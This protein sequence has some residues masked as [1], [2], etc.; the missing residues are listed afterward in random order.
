MSN[1]SDIPSG[2]VA[3]DQRQQPPHTAEERQLIKRVFGSPQ[4]IPGEWLEW[5][6]R[7]LDLKASKNKITTGGAIDF[8]IASQISSRYLQ[9][10]DDGNATQ[11]QTDFGIYAGRWSSGGLVPLFSP[12][13]A[14]TEDGG[15][16][17]RGTTG[18]FTT[19]LL[20]GPLPPGGDGTWS[21]AAWVSVRK[22]TSSA[23]GSGAT[24]DIRVNGVSVLINTVHIADEA[25]KLVAANVSSNP[26]GDFDMIC[27]ADDVTNGVALRIYAQLIPSFMAPGA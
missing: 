8:Q 9:A 19:P 16:G 7:K 5:L 17:G 25:C 3:F 12:V 24:F 13:I 10:E 26:A 22:H 11:V 1:L 23:A 6:I 14:L 21:L 18:S 15:N 2:D 4:D 27:T 20:G